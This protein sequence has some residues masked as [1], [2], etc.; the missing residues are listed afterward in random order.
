MELEHWNWGHMLDEGGGALGTSVRDADTLVVVK[1]E[2]R[3]LNTSIKCQKKVG[4][5]MYVKNDSK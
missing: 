1:E 2:V 3:D 5:Q 4:E